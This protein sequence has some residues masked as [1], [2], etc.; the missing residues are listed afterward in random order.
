MQSSFEG[1]FLGGIKMNDYMTYILEKLNQ[2]SREVTFA[3]KVKLYNKNIIAENLILNL[4]NTVYDYNLDNINKINPN[5]VSIDLGD[6]MNSVAIQ[7][8]SNSTARKVKDTIE[9]FIDNDLYKEYQRLVIV[10]IT[11]KGGT[12]ATYDTEGK[13]AFNKRKDIK[14]LSD[15]GKFIS[16]ITDLDKLKEIEKLLR[17]YFDEIPTKMDIFWESSDLIIRDTKIYLGRDDKD[18][19][20]R[21]DIIDFERNDLFI[22][23][24]K[25]GSGKS[26]FVKI[27]LE[28]QK[29]LDKNSVLWIKGYDE[30][31]SDKLSFA[32][33]S[34]VYSCI[35]FDSFEQV[36]ENKKLTAVTSYV[37]DL[38]K[39]KTS[40]VICVR[41]YNYPIT[42]IHFTDVDTKKVLEINEFSNEEIKPILKKHNLEYISVELKEILR[43]PFYLN[44]VL[45]IGS[46]VGLSSLMNEY[47]VI[48]H[49]WSIM[50]KKD[51]SSYPGNSECLY[52]IGESLIKKDDR[53]V[54]DICTPIILHNLKVDGVLVEKEGVYV[55]S[56]DKFYDITLM[57]FLDK[58]FAQQGSS[59]EGLVSVLNIEGVNRAFLLWIEYKMIQ[60]DIN[61][62]KSLYSYVK[63]ESIDEIS[64]HN[65]LISTVNSLYFHMFLKTNKDDL[66]SNKEL[67]G[68]MF[69][70]A[71]VLPS[72]FVL[73]NI[74]SRTKKG[75]FFIPIKVMPSIYLLDFYNNHLE[76]ND[77]HKEV[78]SVLITINQ[79]CQ[80]F[81]T[82]YDHYARVIMKSFKK[83]YKKLFSS[84]RDNDS[85]KD[86][87][88]IWCN[89]HKGDLDFVDQIMTNLIDQRDNGLSR[90]V[91][92]RVTEPNGYFLPKEFIERY[93][94]IVREILYNFTL[95]GYSE[96][97]LT[98]Y[99]YDDMESLYG[100][101]EYSSSFRNESFANNNLLVMLRFDMNS[102][103]DLLLDIFKEVVNNVKNSEAKKGL[104]DFKFTYKGVS[105]D[106][107]E[108]NDISFMY[109]YRGTSSSSVPAILKSYLMSFEYFLLEC[110]KENT[111]I[112]LVIEKIMQSANSL[113]LISPVISIFLNNPVKYMDYL[114]DLLNTYEIL[115]FDLSRP[116][117]EQFRL[118]VPSKYNDV[119][120][121]HTEMHRNR[122]QRIFDVLFD[123]QVNYN[124]EDIGLEI[125]NAL[126]SLDESIPTS[127]T[128]N[129]HLLRVVKSHTQSSNYMNFE[130]KEKKGDYYIYEKKV[131]DKEFEDL[132]KKGQEE[133]LSLRKPLDLQMNLTKILDS[134]NPKMAIDELLMY[135]EQIETK[136]VYKDFG[137]D[138]NHELI[139]LILLRDYTINEQLRTESI[140]SIKK[141]I[142]DHIS[143]HQAPLIS[144]KH[145]V[146]S[147]ERLDDDNLT[148]KYIRFLVHQN[149]GGF[150]N[151]RDEIKTSSYL[152]KFIKKITNNIIKEFYLELTY[153]G[154][155]IRYNLTKPE[156]SMIAK[157]IRGCK[158][159]LFN[160][161][162]YTNFDYYSRLLVEELFFFSSIKE[163]TTKRLSGLAKKCYKIYILEESP[164]DFE[165]MNKIADYVVKDIDLMNEITTDIFTV[166][167][168]RS[169]EFLKML[170]D[171]M[172]KYIIN[173]ENSNIMVK[174]IDTNAK[175]YNNHLMNYKENRDVVASLQHLIGYWAY[176]NSYLTKTPLFDDIDAL[177]KRYLIFENTKY[178]YYAVAFNIRKFPDTFNSQDVLRLEDYTTEDTL[179]Y[180]STEYFIT[181]SLVQVI[182]NDEELT[183][184]QNKKIIGMLNRLII[185]CSSVKAYLY[186]I[187]LNSKH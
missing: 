44:F 55:F 185:D 127:K 87:I 73:R 161:M 45:L 23:K 19:V 85:K 160:L 122:S 108:L 42:D 110:E 79:T 152:S 30:S 21:K 53:Q 129:N 76:D 27:K 114:I 92:K 105:R 59:V 179:N 32:I 89:F 43:N 11:T 106:L 13:F 107:V 67:I 99:R 163:K 172:I 131:K 5:S 162:R 133:N 118:V 1:C 60:G 3:N 147:L 173:N 178:T 104:K 130:K 180:S 29:L 116:A 153:D 80:Y 18:V 14:D 6:K 176:W 115:Y 17:F 64:R 10:N 158:A 9:K 91:F 101:Y 165:L 33:H 75:T 50:T 146:D 111:N 187:I 154:S 103:V 186:K 100:V 88:S 54:S 7:V 69:N 149:T 181:E 98:Y 124:L 16:M 84:Y 28:M 2:I 184:E 35:I 119:N 63:N 41:D 137:I 97:K 142:N 49:I 139:S 96:E 22:I 182:E 46:N 102:T 62:Y 120:K 148:E 65:V 15:V 24:G 12:R 4:F 52:K 68:I 25:S 78:V 20:S 144:H 123:I 90:E 175:H 86:F 159:Y 113:L 135:L 174:F 166:S 143:S 74:E 170:T 183:I 145:L 117:V 136:N 121:K 140:T 164:N 8:T 70:V 58:Q 128:K 57:K 39:I 132:L 151:L 126:T 72:S 156:E 177:M 157:I 34:Q 77:L 138:I 36:V 83:S 169:Y 168:R 26:A 71:K 150:I 31:I 93:Y 134:N 155:K 95:N 81:G 94:S 82:F 61:F 38:L 171:S 125:S 167:T 141:Y 56:H 47:D 40:V 66:V 112:D 109:A 37:K 48:N 51:T